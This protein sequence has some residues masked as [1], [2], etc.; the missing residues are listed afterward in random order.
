[1]GIKISG[2]IP[3][4]QKQI[5]ATVVKLE[6]ELVDCLLAASKWN[7][8]GSSVT[9]WLKRAD[10][11][12]LQIHTLKTKCEEKVYDFV[13]E[14]LIEGSYCGVGGGI[15]NWVIKG[16]N[17][18]GCDVFTIAK[19]TQIPPPVGTFRYCTFKTTTFR[20]TEG[21]MLPCIPTADIQLDYQLDFEL[22]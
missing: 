7:G 11:K 19:R 9:K 10:Y 1:M 5:D 4:P 2:Y 8:A 13:D 16:Y 22:N 12:T 20:Q 18:L 17:P 6:N 3:Y 14:S 15:G 21:D